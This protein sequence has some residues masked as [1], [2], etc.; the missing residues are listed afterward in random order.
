MRGVYTGICALTAIVLG[1]Q[2][3]LARAQEMET[4]RGVKDGG[5]SVAGWSGKIDAREAAAGQALTNAKLTKE[6]DV[7]HVT[8]G[9][10][11][12]Y[13]NPANKA[14]GDYTVKATFTEPKYMAL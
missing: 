13:W 14:T 1:S 12:T 4:S 9:P 8:T 5:I 11:V 6:G 7:L 3:N 10:A 2:I